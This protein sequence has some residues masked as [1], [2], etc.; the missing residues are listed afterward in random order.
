MTADMPDKIF[1]RIFAYQISHEI[2]IVKMQ[3]SQSMKN[4]DKA[5]VSSIMSLTM[6]P[7]V[8]EEGGNLLVITFVNTAAP[9]VD[10]SFAIIP[11]A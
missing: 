6:S 7:F 8:E 11:R 10:S 4:F 9:R 5:Q 1:T 2:P 3:S